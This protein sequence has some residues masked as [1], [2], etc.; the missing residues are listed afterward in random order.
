MGCLVT[1]KESACLIEMRQS[2]Q[3]T[4][5]LAVALMGRG[6]SQLGCSLS[7]PSQPLSLHQMFSAGLVP[8]KGCCLAQPAWERDL[9][10]ANASLSEYAAVAFHRDRLWNTPPPKAPQASPDPDESII[11]STIRQPSKTLAFLW[12]SALILFLAP[13]TSGL[14]ISWHIGQ[15][16]KPRCSRRVKNLARGQMDN[17][18]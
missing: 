17:W 5:L 6:A 7:W 8:Q 9:E 13:N 18:W 14:F 12:Q 15:R 2:S 10:N 3:S 16:N 1:W 4:L 11:S